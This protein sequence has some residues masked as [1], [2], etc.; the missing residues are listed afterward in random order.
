[1]MQ[2][3]KIFFLV[4]MAFSSMLL[5]TGCSKDYL[6]K[7]PA[8]SIA[9]SVFWKTQG[10]AAAWRA[11]IYRQLQATIGTG[12]WSD[13]GETRSDNME[14]SGSG[15]NTDLL[16]NTV[17]ANDAGT[18]W[19]SLYTTISYCN[20]GIKYYPQMIAEN[21]DGG[22]TVY[23]GYLGECYALRALMYFYGLRVW[24]SIPIVNVPIE[25]ID[26]PNLYAQS[27]VDSVKLQILSDIN[28]A[29]KYIT[30]DNTKKYYINQAGVYALQTD[31]YMWVQDYQNAIAASLKCETSSGCTLVTNPTDWKN[32]FLNPATSTETI[33]NL[34]WNAAEY[35]AG[36]GY[37]TRFG[38][39]DGTNNYQP[40]AGTTASPGPFLDL[41]LRRDTSIHT[42]N[43]YCDGRF[44][45]SFD[46]VA[47]GNGAAANTF[48]LAYT[49]AS[50][51][52]M[53]PWDPTQ[54]SIN[55]AS[56]S[57]G[58]FVYP[59]T[60]LNSVMM[61]VY[62]FADILLLRAEAYNRTGDTADAM[63][64]V[65]NIRFRTGYTTTTNTA[66]FNTGVLRSQFSAQAEL[67][68]KYGSP[69]GDSLTRSVERVILHERQLELF[70]E[71]KRWFDLCRIGHLDGNAA[72]GYYYL[73]ERMD[74]LLNGQAKRTPFIQG[75][76]MGRVFFPVN[77]NALNANGLL[78][79]NPAYA[80]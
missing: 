15:V 4:V 51:G 58:K 63:K 21:R 61:P 19:Q 23:I 67:T 16:Y 80:N 13:W 77:A 53:I 37:A 8:S 1:M 57:L 44:W 5:Y 31:Y 54:K 43:N 73:H 79:Q 27:P 35:G 11:G 78:K 52:K 34:F 46:T 9:P 6:D 49:A 18:S 10:D 2:K 56:K 48:Y 32:I 41:Y 68:A 30:T 47:Y 3:I 33:F 17:G 20:Y 14:V 69:T 40:R 25:T 70:C 39:S 74:P 42:L 26:Q 22:A 65:N 71:G 29:L 75:N 66:S 12:N 38:R 55:T 28:T 24:G 7:Q 64:I 45:N 72:D 62:R 50:C 36:A 59:A 60:L 76:N